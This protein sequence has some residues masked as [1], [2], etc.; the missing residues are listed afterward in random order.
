MP[1]T[2]AT[3]KVSLTARSAAAT[4][5]LRALVQRDDLKLLSVA[6]SE[7]AISFSKSNPAFLTKVRDVYDELATATTVNKQRSSR[8]APAKLIPIIEP[9]QIGFGPNDMLDPYKLYRLYGKEQFAQALGD[10]LMPDLK[11]ASEIVMEHN[12]GTKPKS[13]AR[14]DDLIDYIVEYIP[15]GR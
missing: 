13:K 14:R 3:K 4:A 15:K 11:R 5:E 6:L 12:P 2:T 8:K 7:A 10:Y 9:G 1:S